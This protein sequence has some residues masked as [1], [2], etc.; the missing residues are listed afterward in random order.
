MLAVGWDLM[1]EDVMAVERLL[2]RVGGSERISNL[3]MWAELTSSMY[4]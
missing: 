2:D 4:R 3:S 1:Y